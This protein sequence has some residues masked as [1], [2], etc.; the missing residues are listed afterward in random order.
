MTNVAK[1]IEL[2]GTSEQGW[3]EAAQTELAKKEVQGNV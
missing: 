3:T 1:V 2:G